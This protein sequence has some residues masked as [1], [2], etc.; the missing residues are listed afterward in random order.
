MDAFVGVTAGENVT[1]DKA[2]FEIV[3]V[4]V[5][6]GDAWGES[7]DDNETGAIGA[8]TACAMNNFWHGMAGKFGEG[9]GVINEDPGIFMA[10][11]LVEFAEVDGDVNV[12]VEMAEVAMMIGGGDL[13][14]DRASGIGFDELIGP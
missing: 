9:F 1:L 14:E 8:D 2:K 12:A 13:L 10:W 6:L 11:G 3:L 4:E 7:A 5:I